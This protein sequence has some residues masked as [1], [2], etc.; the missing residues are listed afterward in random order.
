M[1]TSTLLRSLALGSVLTLAWNPLPA[2]AETPQPPPRGGMPLDRMKTELS[3][4][5]DQLEE[6]KI[7][8]DNHLAKVEALR[9]NTSLTREQR[10]EQ[11]QA[12]RQAWRE[13][14]LA[15]L[16]PEQRE[17]FQQMRAKYRQMKHGEDRSTDEKPAGLPQGGKKQRPT[18]PVTE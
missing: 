18:T 1:K 9:A 14:I 11:R 15:V 3:L 8:Q 4:T 17:K 10:R 7:I 2:S 16:T 12:I 6:L 5:Q 13:E